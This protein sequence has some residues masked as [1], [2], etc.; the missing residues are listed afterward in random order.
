[1]GG[2][3]GFICRWRE[4]IWRIFVVQQFLDKRCVVQVEY[5]LDENSWKWGIKEGQSISFDLH[6]REGLKYRVAHEKPAR[7][8][9]D[10]R[11][12]KLTYKEIIFSTFSNQ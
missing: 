8:L 3:L 1:M 6:V 10:Q 2:D 9:V 4:L 5:W 11:A 12:Q 7:R